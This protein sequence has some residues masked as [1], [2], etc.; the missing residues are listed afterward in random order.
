MP[1]N[2]LDYPHAHTHRWIHTDAD[3]P[4]VHISVRP[5]E[6]TQIYE[7]WTHA[8]VV[9][10]T[11][12]YLL[13]SHTLTLVFQVNVECNTYLLQYP[14]MLTQKWNPDL[15]LLGVSVCLF[16]MIHTECISFF[17][18]K[19]LRECIGNRRI[20]QFKLH[21]TGALALG[22]WFS[23]CE[24][25]SSLTQVLAFLQHRC[26]AQLAQAWASQRNGDIVT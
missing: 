14:Q 8:A 1:I 15:L 26:E 22:G 25:K 13:F 3:I 20:S 21:A 17:L 2:L 6:S 24:L 23:S 19:G 4:R 18:A 11:F 9:N 5:H 16:F 7:K 12:S 10:S